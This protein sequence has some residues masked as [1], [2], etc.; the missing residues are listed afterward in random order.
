MESQDLLSERFELHRTGL[1]ALA[2]RMLGSTVE[3]DDAVQETWLRLSRSD[4]RTIENL[5]GWLTTVLTRI[6]LDLLRARAARREEPLAGRTERTIPPSA[7]RTDPQHVV[8]LADDVGLALLMVLDNLSPAER[9]A[10]VLHDVFGISFTEIGPLVERTPTA[11]RKLAS[12]AR[13]RLRG[14]TVPQV[15]LARRWQVAEIFLRATQDGDL[16]ALLAV[17]DRDVVRRAD[18]QA[19]PVGTPT[20]LRGADAV[21]EGTLRYSRTAR[22]FARVALVAGAPGIVVAPQGRLRLVLRLTIE[23]DTVTEIDVIGAPDR[24][25]GLQVRLVEPTRDTLEQMFECV[26]TIP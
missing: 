21:A 20:E 5:G 14:A 10:F 8:S 6:C 15:D 16:D 17:L 3:A 19:I 1:R 9:V 13:R 24:L 26:S 11:A 23:N 7:E 4:T 18:R 2:H 12:R 22:H 25:T